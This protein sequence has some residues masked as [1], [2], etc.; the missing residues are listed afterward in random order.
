MT[1]PPA[2]TKGL[3]RY[4]VALEKEEPDWQ[5]GARAVVVPRAGNHAVVFRKALAGWSNSLKPQLG[6]GVAQ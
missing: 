2:L 3:L 1:G 4:D 6:L 5:P